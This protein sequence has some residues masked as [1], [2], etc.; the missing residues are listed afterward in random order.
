[1][2]MI[3]VS[4]LREKMNMK[5]AAPPPRF[6]IMQLWIVSVKQCTIQGNWEELERQVYRSDYC[7]KAKDG[8]MARK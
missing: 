6:I 4:K 5:V 3:T 7:F 8:E 2:G 1:M